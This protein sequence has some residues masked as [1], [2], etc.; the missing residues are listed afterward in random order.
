MNPDNK[1][2]SS[3]SSLQDLAQGN[4]GLM[5]PDL[6]DDT[7]ELNGQANLTTSTATAEVMS[8]SITFTGLMKMLRVFIDAVQEL[9]L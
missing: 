6:I 2:S 7:A 5:V 4:Y 8:V 9:E 1:A 3:E